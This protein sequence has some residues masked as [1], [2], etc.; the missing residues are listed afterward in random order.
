MYQF[1]TTPPSGN[2]RTDILR[3]RALA[4]DLEYACAGKHPRDRL[5][6]EAPVLH[7]WRLAYRTEICLVGNVTGHPDMGYGHLAKTSG[8]WLLSKKLGYARTLS[9]F[10]SLG[11]P[12]ADLKEHN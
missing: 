8:L 6:D 2:I 4:Q 5:I 11:C 9:R 10:Y 7:N 1:D 12:A 3:L